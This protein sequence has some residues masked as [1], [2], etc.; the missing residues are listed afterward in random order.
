MGSALLA[1]RCGP[2][3]IITIYQIKKMVRPFLFI[4]FA[5]FKSTEP[6]LFKNDSG[7]VARLDWHL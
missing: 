5:M 3:K 1:I 4:I 6:K 2:P 7:K